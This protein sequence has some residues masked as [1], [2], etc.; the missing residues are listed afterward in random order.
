MG[1]H[2]KGGSDERE[3]GAGKTAMGEEN[4]GRQDRGEALSLRGGGIEARLNS[5]PP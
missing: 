1:S 4:G 3:K 5:L 2:D